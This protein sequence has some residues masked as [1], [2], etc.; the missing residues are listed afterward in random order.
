MHYSSYSEIIIKGDPFWS[1][2]NYKT[3]GLRY[4]SYKSQGY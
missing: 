1:T 4:L 2:S 3:V